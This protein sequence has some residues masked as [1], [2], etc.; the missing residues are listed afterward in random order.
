MKITSLFFAAILFCTAS[1]GQGTGMPSLNMTNAP[2]NASFIE[3]QRSFPRPGEAL[4]RKEDTLQKQ[5]AA[6]GMQWP[7]RYIY[8]RSFKYD[9]QLE[10]WVKNNPKEEYKLFKNYRVCALAGSLGPKRMEGDYQVP[11][12]F[13][14]INEFNP[15]SNYHLSLGLNYP[16]A[17]DKVLSDMFKPGGDIY[18]HGSC[19]TVGCIPLNDQ[20][21]EELYILAAHARNGGQ[22]FIPVHI[23]P[24]RYNNKRSNDY[25]ATLTKTDAQLKTFA[26]NLE[27]VYD[28]FEITRQL[29]LIMTNSQGHYIYDGL[30]KKLPPPPPPPKRVPKPHRTRTITALAEVVH[31]WPQFPGGNEHFLKYL[32]KMGKA[33]LPTLPAGKKKAY[34]V[35]EFIVDSDGTP[36]NFKMVQGV[37]E[38]FDDELITVLEQMPAWKPAL[39]NDK[40]VAKKIRQ[41][42][43][44][45]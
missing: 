36:T 19:V 28:H 13:Y 29:P 10:V 26:Q 33:L 22:D 40:P 38:E 27:L 18:I 25:L 34:V 4:K 35:V 2:I 8:I 24:I 11:E 5:F 21:I 9:G 45:E 20:Q 12:G 14:Y 30:T 17:S 1:F 31:Q 43:G 7:A 23:F 42:F 6:K 39:L 16:N 37:D 15:R 32:D 44:I 41:G 3:W